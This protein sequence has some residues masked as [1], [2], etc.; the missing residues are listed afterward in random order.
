VAVTPTG[1]RGL[2]VDVACTDRPALL[3][4]IAK[5]LASLGIDV[6]Q[7]VIDTT[8]WYVQ[9]SFEGEVSGPADAE[10]LERLREEVLTAADARPARQP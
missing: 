8:G 10:A 2:T 5:R 6:R 1:G 4:D 3:Y 7:A 9:D